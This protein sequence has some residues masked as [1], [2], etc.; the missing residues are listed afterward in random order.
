VAVRKLHSFGLRVTDV[1]RSIAF[2]QDIF[3]AAIQ[4]RQGDTVCLRIGDG[5]RFFSLAPV[6]AGEQARISHIGLSVEGFELEAVRAQ[7]CAFGVEPGLQPA[8]GP[9]TLDAAMTSWTVSRDREAGGGAA[10]T[11]DLYFAGREA[12]VFHLSS[13]DHCGGSGALGTVCEDVEAVPVEGLFK[14]IELSHF[15]NFLANSAR[16]NAFYMQAF[17]KQFQAY[18]GPS[19]LVGVGDGT[20]FL[21]FVGGS[22]EGPPANPARIAHVCLS[23]EKFS[24]DHILASLDDYGFSARESNSNTPPMVHWVSMRMPNRGGIEGGTPEVYFSDPDGLQ[25]QLQD[26]VYCGGGGYL[27]DSCE[28]LV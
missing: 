17:G 3:G 8:A 5:P 15:T 19:P 27:G 28:A 14:S 11:T 2:Y 6:R 22:E 7:L 24:V 16:A 13:A 9:P 12:L 18:Q 10:G 25:I 4:A 26:A 21:M 23:M 1:A 20:Q